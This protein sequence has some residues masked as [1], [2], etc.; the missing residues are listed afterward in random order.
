M[1]NQELVAKVKDIA[2]N[3]KTMYVYGSFGSPLTAANK[4]RFIKAWAYNKQALVQNKILAASADTFG[5]DCVNLIKGILWGWNGNKNATNGGA[6]YGANGVPDVNADGFIALCKNVSKDFSKIEVGEAVHCSG[7]IGVYIGNGLAVEC[8]PAWA[9]KVQITAVGNIGAKAGYPTRTWTDHGKIPYITYVAN[10]TATKPT[11]TATTPTTPT[12]SHKFKVGDKVTVSS[13][14]K[15]SDA[16]VKDAVIYGKK[17]KSG[18]ITKIVDARNPYLV[19]NGNS[20]ICW[21]ND[22][23][24][25]VCNGVSMDKPASVAYFPKYT[26]KSN[27]LVDALSSLNIDF[28]PDYRTKIAKANGIANYT[29]SAKQNTQLLNKLKQGTLIKP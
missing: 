24:I 3:Y 19:S 29:K 11:T 2:Q 25:R 14:Y 12:T 5:F 1:T 28:T 6:T 20:P 17:T 18:T 21:C 10:T 16:P 23:D 27:S 7:H 4:Q 22:G 26:G 13:G 8:T 9:N 15:S